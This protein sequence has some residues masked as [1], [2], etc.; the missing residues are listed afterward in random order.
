MK[1]YFLG[2]ILPTLEKRRERGDFIAVYRTSK[3]LEK[4]DRNDLFV[5]DNRTRKEIVKDYMQ[6]RHKKIQLPI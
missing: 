6:E 3:G 2:L 5:W 1:K 4:F